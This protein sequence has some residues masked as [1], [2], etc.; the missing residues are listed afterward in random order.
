MEPRGILNALPPDLLLC[1]LDY[2]TV[3]V[4]ER[5]F[6]MFWRQWPFMGERGNLIVEK[7]QINQFKFILEFL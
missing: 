7:M 3:Q 4:S 6:R 5:L 1:A 2:F